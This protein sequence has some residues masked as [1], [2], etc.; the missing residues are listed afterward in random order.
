M[1]TSV[2]NTRENMNR[3]NNTAAAAKI[4][5]FGQKIGGARK[6]YYAALK[7]FVERLEG[8]SVDALKKS[9]LSKL[10]NLP[11]LARLCTDGAISEDAA[12]AVWT[13]WRSVGHRPGLAHRLNKWAEQTAEKMAKIAAI[14][15]GED[16]PEDVRK[17]TDFQV[18]TAANWPAESFSFGRFEV[19]A[20]DLIAL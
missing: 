13:L 9:A 17:R 11:D 1:N 6:D 20:P 14:M 15:A 3:V 18:M 7:D 8:V 4:E 16:V 10:V 5:D 2:N 19:C 12:R